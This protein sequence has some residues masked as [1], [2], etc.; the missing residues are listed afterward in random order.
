MLAAAI[1]RLPEILFSLPLLPRPA[2]RQHRCTWLKIIL[3]SSNAE[4]LVHDAERLANPQNVLNRVVYDCI[5]PNPNGLKQNG[6]APAPPA[7]SLPPYYTRTG[8]DVSVLPRRTQQRVSVSPRR[9]Q[10]YFIFGVDSASHGTGYDAYIRVPLRKWKPA[11]CHTSVRLSN[12]D[13]QCDGVSVT[14]LYVA[15][16][17]TSTI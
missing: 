15:A 16:T 4:M 6:Q 14:Q 2:D 12:A 13:W 10:Q 8:P 11:P 7:G 17:S 1:R 5:E 3:T 9:T